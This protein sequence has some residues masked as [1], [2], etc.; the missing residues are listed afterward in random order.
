VIR[1][2]A[3]VLLVVALLGFIA[4][5]LHA[6]RRAQS[7]G[8]P[9][10]VGD[11]TGVAGL[12][13][14]LAT[15]GFGVVAKLPEEKP[16]PLASKD[17]YS[18]EGFD[19]ERSPSRR[20]A[21][22]FIALGDDPSVIQAEL[23]P[24][25]SSEDDPYYGKATRSVWRLPGGGEITATHTW[26]TPYSIISL[27]VVVPEKGRSRFAL[28]RGLVLG[29]SQLRDYFR[30]WGRPAQYQT[31]AAGDYVV[32]Y[33]ACVGKRVVWLKLDQRARGERAYAE[34]LDTAT[35]TSVLAFYPDDRPAKC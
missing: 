22:G 13:V 23:G 34:T 6:R 30:A 3:G 28:H 2:L 11:T 7:G 10:S 35:V 19:P 32:T 24:P 31:S 9:W 8:K 5:V 29:V 16:V 12:V 15:S 18:V 20:D 33:M 21:I 14:V 17:L 4:V 25:R 26:D 1:I 27:F